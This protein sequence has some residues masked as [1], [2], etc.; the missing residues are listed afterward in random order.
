[1]QKTH[2]VAGDNALVRSNMEIPTLKINVGLLVH[3]G[4]GAL[5]MPKPKSYSLKSNLGFSSIIVSRLK[6][7]HIP[8]LDGK[9]FKISV[10]P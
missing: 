10:T 1:M 4:R 3:R 8:S 6:V 5:I 2:N 7:S 9:A